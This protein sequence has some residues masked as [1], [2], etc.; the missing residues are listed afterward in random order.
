[1]VRSRGVVYV[2]IADLIVR[3]AYQMGKTPLLPIFA[4]SIGAGDVLLGLIVSVSTM[5]GIFFKPFVGFLSDRYGRRMWLIVGTSFFVGVP[6][7]YRFVNSPEQLLLVRMIHGVA[8]SIYGPVT[9]AYVAEQ[10]QYGRGERL[11]W[12]SMA[13]N[14]GYV[15]GPALAG[16][17]LLWMTPVAVFTFIGIVSSL[18]ILPMIYLPDTISSRSQRNSNILLQGLRA[19]GYVSR[20]PMVWLGGGLRATMFIALYAVKAFLP[21]YALSIGMNIALVGIFFALQEMIHILLSPASGRIGDVIGYHVAVT[22]GMVILAFALILVATV[23]SIFLLVVVASMM[24]FARSLV[25][26]SVVASVSH[27]VDGENLGIGMGVLG[28]IQNT[29]KVLGPALA[30][31]LVHWFDY[32]FTFQFIGIILLIGAFI[33]FCYSQYRNRFIQIEQ[34]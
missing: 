9:L 18:A 2:T 23:D 21:I 1:M 7:V 28:S 13:R 17:M 10:S 27:K 29:G 34:M 19:F 33:G 20:I 26:P 30:G 25:F 14:I 8:T 5:T 3:S 6:F 12:F 4:A 31:V 15:I 24:G 32:I 16:Y 11:A 22:S